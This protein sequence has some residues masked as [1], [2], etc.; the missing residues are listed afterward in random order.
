MITGTIG[1]ERLPVAVPQAEREL[2]GHSQLSEVPA[3]A[4]ANVARC[5]NRDRGNIGMR[6]RQLVRV[7]DLESP[8]DDDTA[9]Y[10]LPAEELERQKQPA[11]PRSARRVRRSARP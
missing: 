10:E 8:A 5:H 6:G 2:L 4:D 7:R 1:D 9:E 3:G 11:R